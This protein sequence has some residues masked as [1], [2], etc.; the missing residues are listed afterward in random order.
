MGGSGGSS[1][2][3]QQTT[4]PSDH[5]PPLVPKQ[6][7]LRTLPHTTHLRQPTRPPQRLR[8]FQV[9][10]HRRRQ[11]TAWHPGHRRHGQH[12]QGEHHRAEKSRSLS[13]ILRTPTINATTKPQQLVTLA[14]APPSARTPV[15]VSFKRIKQG[16]AKRGSD[17]HLALLLHLLQWLRPH[18]TSTRSKIA[19]FTCPNLPFHQ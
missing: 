10:V 17:A 13:T 16:T 3:R 8:H 7:T 2:E 15:A 6:M 14:L 5:T 4:G 9:C 18:Q 19:I 1:E 12:E 11:A